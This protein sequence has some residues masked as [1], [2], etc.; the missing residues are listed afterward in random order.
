MDPVIVVHGGAWDIPPGLL[1]PSIL[2]VRRAASEGYRMLETGASALDAVERAVMVMEDDPAFNAGVGSVLNEEGQVEMD[3]MVMDGSS[4]KFGSVA[5]VRRVKNPISLARAIMERTSDLMFVSEG[6]ERV[7]M[8]LGI[9]LVDPRTLIVE[10]QLRTWRERSSK[11]EGTVG[12]V[13]IDRDGR[14]AAAT[15]TGGKPMKKPGRVG[16]TPL[17][18]CGAYANGIGGASSTGQGG[19]IMRVMLSRL[20][21]DMLT[22]LDP[23][24]AARRSLSVMADRTGG[25]GGIIVLDRRGRIGYAHTSKRMAVAYSMGGEIVA[26]IS[27]LE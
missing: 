14:I 25:W 6:A 8:E 12:A 19:P 17:I 23:I 26:K 24:E 11:Q 1:E 21:V 2:C 27:S 20:A 18:G 3:A 22:G 5:A 16:D 4:L 13:A 9:P 15:S 7:A 10:R